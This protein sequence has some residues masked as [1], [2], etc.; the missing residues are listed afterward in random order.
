VRFFSRP[1][2]LLVLALIFLLAWLFGGPV[3]GVDLPLIEYAAE[4]RAWSPGFARFAASFTHFGGAAVTLG[5]AA[6][7]AVSL[8]VRRRPGAALLLAGTVLTERFLVDGLKAWIG[9]PRP[10]IDPLVHLPQSLAYPSGHAANSMAAFLAVALIA[11]PARYRWATAVAA[12]VLAVLVGC[13]RILLGV[14]WPSDVIGGWALGMLCVGVALLVGERSG[15]L[16]VES[17]HDV[18]GRHELPVDQQESA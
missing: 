17:Q 14:H 8:F 7:A 6:V 13:S 15:V 11:A 2:A 3:N 4:I 5:I 18:V 16:L 10:A 1:I 12:L 9:R